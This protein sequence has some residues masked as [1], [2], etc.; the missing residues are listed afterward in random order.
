MVFSGLEGA[1]CSTAGEA[2]N[3]KRV[4]KVGM[5]ARAFQWLEKGRIIFPMFVKMRFSTGGAGRK[6][7]PLFKLKEKTSD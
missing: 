7:S 1:Q 2:D 3:R 5:A 6:T 4:P